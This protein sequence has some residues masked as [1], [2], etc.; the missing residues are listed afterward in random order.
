MEKHSGRQVAV[1]LR[2]VKTRNACCAI[3]KIKQYGNQAWTSVSPALRRG[4]KVMSWKPVS[5]TE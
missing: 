1:T 4:R 3:S 5:A 2:H